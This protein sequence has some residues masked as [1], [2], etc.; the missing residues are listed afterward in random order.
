M[1]LFVNQNFKIINSLVRLKHETFLIGIMTFSSIINFFFLG[2]VW[3]NCSRFNGREIVRLILRGRL[4]SDQRSRELG[5]VGAKARYR[6]RVGL[7]CRVVVKGVYHLHGSSGS[8]YLCQELG[9][10]KNWTKR[11]SLQ[12]L[13]FYYYS[14]IEY[15]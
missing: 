12:T 9:C 11:S 8:A 5:K 4:K 10:W 14:W 6:S 7:A 2:K 15:I 3:K 1:K 13:V